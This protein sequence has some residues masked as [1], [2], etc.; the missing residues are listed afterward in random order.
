LVVVVLKYI[1]YCTTTRT[2]M[3]C[4]QENKNIQPKLPSLVSV[5]QIYHNNH[6]CLYKFIASHFYIEFCVKIYKNMLVLI[7]QRNDNVI[8]VNGDW[9][10]WFFAVKSWHRISNIWVSEEEC[11]GWF[12]LMKLWRID[13]LYI[14]LERQC[15]QNNS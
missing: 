4:F 7:R 2:V 14:Y 3:V 8:Y 9:H 6:R 1:I 5:I 15:L 12:Y 13:E 11:W 10:Y